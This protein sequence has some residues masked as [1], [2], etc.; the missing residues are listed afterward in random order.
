MTSDDDP[1]LNDLGQG[2]EGTH[3]DALE[4]MRA[5]AAASRTDRDEAINKLRESMTDDEIRDDFG[6]DLREIEG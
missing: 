4:V 3:W 2:R 1:E 5:R 6:I